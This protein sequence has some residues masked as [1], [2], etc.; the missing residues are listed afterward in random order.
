MDRRKQTTLIRKEE[1]LVA[2]IIINEIQRLMRMCACVYGVGGQC[3]LSASAFFQNNL[4]VFPHSDQRFSELRGKLPF[5]SLRWSRSKSR[6]PSK[7]GN[8]HPYRM[9]CE[10]LLLSCWLGLIRAG[11]RKQTKSLPGSRGQH[12]W[13]TGCSQPPQM[14]QTP[15][16]AL[17]REIMSV[18]DPVGTREQAAPSSA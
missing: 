4:T 15:G 10:L 18:P 3:S 16:N 14:C 7:R 11:H 2:L 6:I 8:P 9:L 17:A 5:P 13:E 12:P 1:E